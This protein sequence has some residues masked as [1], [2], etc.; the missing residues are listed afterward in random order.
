[1]DIT[2]PDAFTGFNIGTIDVGKNA[3]PYTDGMNGGTTVSLMSL[4]KMTGDG[5][6]FKIY[7][8]IEGVD[9][10]EFTIKVKCLSAGDSEGKN[11]MFSATEKK[12]QLAS[13]RVP[14]DADE[15]GI[16]DW[17]DLI[18][19]LKYVSLWDVSINLSN[20]EVTGNG[21]VNWDDLILLLKYVSLWDV[22]LK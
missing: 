10:K 5:N 21:V 8:D 9:L 6:L 22:Q 16:V 20:A 12:I 1:M 7:L 4:D 14:G 2:V 11:V 15:N 13:N 17:G 18:L 19:I 3:V